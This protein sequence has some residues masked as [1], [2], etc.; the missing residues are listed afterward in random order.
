MCGTITPYDDDGD[1]MHTIYSAAAPEY[2][3]QTFFK[4][5]SREIEKVKMRFPD[6]T[7]VGVADGAPENWAFLEPLTS[8]QVLDFYHVSEYVADAAEA[9]F[10][11]K[12]N[13]P[14]RRVWLKSRLH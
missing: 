10:P 9:L 13:C 3:M 7:Y 12:K 4:R 14:E 5:F 11:M 6:A 1:R 8:V 2:G